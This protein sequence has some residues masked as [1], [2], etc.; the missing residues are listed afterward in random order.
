M[1]SHPVISGISHRIIVKKENRKDRI[2]SQ[3][4]ACQIVEGGKQCHEVIDEYRGHLIC[5]WCQV[6]WR[7]KEENVG[8][9]LKFAEFKRGNSKANIPTQAQ[10]EK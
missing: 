10:T 9:V 6:Q 1:N 3:C 8:R 7:S 2:M 4:E 5:C